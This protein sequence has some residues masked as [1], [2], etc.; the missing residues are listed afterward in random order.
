MCTFVFIDGYPVGDEANAKDSTALKNVAGI[1]L[2]GRAVRLSGRL[3]CCQGRLHQAGLHR[4]RR[5]RPTP[6]AAVTA[7]A[8][9]RALTPLLHG[10]GREGRDELLLAV[11]CQLLR[12]PRA[13]D[14]GRRLVSELALRSSSP[15]AVPCSQ[16]ISAAAAANDGKVV[17][18]DVDQ[19]GKSD[20]VITSAM[21]G[22][23]ASAAVGSAARSMTVPSTRSAAP[24]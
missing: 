22:L 1:C 15:A 9:C 20:T 3:R 6:P 2:P 11:R 19:S 5:R 16:S 13:A 10:V 18:V 12:F 23:S 4:W 8:S 24:S 21:K 14:H 7:M 17:G